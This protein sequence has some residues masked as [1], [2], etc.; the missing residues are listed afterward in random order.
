[1]PLAKWK[2]GYANSK[3][4]LVV[5]GDTPHSH[6]LF[7]AVKVGCIPVVI[8][9]WYPFYAPPFPTTLDMQDFCIFLPEEEFLSNPEKALQSLRDIPDDEIKSKLESLKWAQQVMIMEHPQSLFVPAFVREAMASFSRP[10]SVLRQK[11]Q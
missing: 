7:N 5:R 11:L 9:D 8:S 6:A 4:C 1:M 10:V 2:Q 3:F